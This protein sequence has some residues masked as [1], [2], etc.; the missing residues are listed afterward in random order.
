MNFYIRSDRLHQRNPDTVQ[1]GT[2]NQQQQHQSEEQSIGCSEPE[3]MVR[4]TVSI[5][6]KRHIRGGNNRIGSDANSGNNRRGK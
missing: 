4:V 1:G 6:V 5:M 3:D 2:K